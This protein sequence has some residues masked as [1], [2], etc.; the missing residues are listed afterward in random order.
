MP[1]HSTV[2]TLRDLAFGAVNGAVFGLMVS[3]TVKNLHFETNPFVFTFV[4]SLL[5]IFGIF[6]GYLLSR[7]KVFLFE[8]AK[9]GAVGAANFSIDIGV[10][11]ILLSLTEKESALLVD[12]FAVISF[13]FAVTNSYFW[14]KYWSFSKNGQKSSKREFHLFIVVSVIGALLSTG[15][16]HL[17]VNIIGTPSWVPSEDPGM[18]WKSIAK[19]FGTIIVL[20]WNFV[21]YRF[22]VFN[23]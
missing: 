15:I 10:Y 1:K 9:F 11:N 12:V 3:L 6:L 2:L 22:F 23:R 20:V 5:A 4:F 13:C 18:L 8:F 19:V 21:G 17:L 7:W 16:V 14:N